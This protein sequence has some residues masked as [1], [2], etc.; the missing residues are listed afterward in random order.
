MGFSGLESPA[1]TMDPVLSKA[2]RKLLN[3]KRRSNIPRRETRKLGRRFK[4]AISTM[5]LNQRKFQD[6]FGILYP[7][8]GTEDFIPQY[9]SSR[10]HA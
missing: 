7:V 8:D 5:K 3:Y 1:Y 2:V 6:T 10:N 9:H 4:I